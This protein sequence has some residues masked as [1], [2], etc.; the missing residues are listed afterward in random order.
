MEGVINYMLLTGDNQ[1]KDDVLNFNFAFTDGSF[2]WLLGPGA[3]SESHDDALWTVLL[4]FKIDEW[5]PKIGKSD[6]RY[7]VSDLCY[8]SLR[9][10]RSADHCF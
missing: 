6:S 3:F 4:Y 1:F 2:N 7:W 9:V 10:H 8:G 5:L